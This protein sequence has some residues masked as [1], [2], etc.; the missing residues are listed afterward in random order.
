MA[1]QNQVQQPAAPTCGESPELTEDQS[2]YELALAGSGLCEMVQGDPVPPTGAEQSHNSSGKSKLGP[3]TGAKSGA[4]G[5]DSRLAVLVS[6][7]P[8]LPESTRQAIMEIVMD[9]VPR[10]E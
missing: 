8:R 1:V 7:W 9:I 6:I 5:T 4:L 10:L 2:G 3:N